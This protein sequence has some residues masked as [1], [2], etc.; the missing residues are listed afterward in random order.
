M[1]SKKSSDGKHSFAS[2]ILII[3]LFG[4]LLIAALVPEQTFEAVRAKEQAQIVSRLGED[5]DQWILDRIFR[6][7]ETVNAEAGNYLEQKESFVGKPAIDQWMVH[8]VYAITIWAHVIL[9]RMGMLILWLAFALPCMLAAFTDGFYQ[10]EISKASFTSQSPVRHKAGLEMVKLISM[11]ML[12]WIFMPVF[13]SII[14]AP[15]AIAAGS[16]AWWMWMS[17]M[18]KRL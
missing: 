3:V 9:Y 7:L 17:N 10:R 8:R 18:Q 13:I 4:S 12:L 11:L 14:I 16:F 5:T 2:I 1:A 15:V 6:W